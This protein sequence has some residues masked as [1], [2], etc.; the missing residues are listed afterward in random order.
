MVVVI[1]TTFNDTVG[2]TATAKLWS[3]GPTVK[4]SADVNEITMLAD[5]DITKEKKINMRELKLTKL[6]S[7]KVNFDGLGVFDYLLKPL[8]NVV[9]KLVKGVLTKEINKQL[10]DA[11]EKIEAIDLD[12]LLK[13]I[14]EA[15][16][17]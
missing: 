3:A 6:G 13:K 17:E 8:T 4:L 7:I 9:L 15:K 1:R 12:E 5:M 14:D 2:Y 10:V 11:Q 16:K